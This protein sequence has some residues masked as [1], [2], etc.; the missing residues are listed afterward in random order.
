MDTHGTIDA[1]VARL[2]ERGAQIRPLRSAP[3]VEEIESRLGFKLP[4]IYRS[5][6]TRHAFPSL[7]LEKVE[8]FANLGDGSEHDL[9]IAPFRD[10]GLSEW[11]ISHRFPQIGR[12]STGS[13]D[14]VCFDLE[15]S[16]TARDPAVIQLD[17]EDILL[18]RRKVRRLTVAPSFLM[19]VQEAIDA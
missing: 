16:R 5:L 14:P 1:L 8:L 3:W 13:Y 19:L 11:L 6:V 12:P 10:A 4:A 2:V 17:H 18:S 9:A 15:S 7:T